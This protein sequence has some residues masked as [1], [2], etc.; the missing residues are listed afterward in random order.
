MTA[1]SSLVDL[2]RAAV[3]AVRSDIDDLRRN[4]PAAR[5]IGDQVV[6]QARGRL[7]RPPRAGSAPAPRVVARPDSA[8]SAPAGTEEPVAGYGLMTAREVVELLKDADPSL[9]AAI[10]SHEAVGRRRRTILEAAEP[11]SGVEDR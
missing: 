5:F 10:A 2:L 8:E 9:R 11:A 7:C 4:A 6:A 1:R 3:S